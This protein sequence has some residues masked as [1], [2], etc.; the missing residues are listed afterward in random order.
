VL[1]YEPRKPWGAIDWRAAD[2]RAR[3]VLSRFGI[4]LDLRRPLGSYPTAIQQL[5][6]IGRAASM[7]ARLLIMDEPTS[8]LD[9]REVETL[10]G[11]IRSLRDRGTSILY[12]SHFLDELFVDP[13]DRVIH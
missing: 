10:F 5:V 6:A 4:E 9:E 8:S 1:G 7:D 11:V 3:E 12:V 2:A 13:G